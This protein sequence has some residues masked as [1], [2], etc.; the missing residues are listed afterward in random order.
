MVLL[1]ETRL[2]VEVP[3]AFVRRWVVVETPVR[4]SALLLVLLLRFVLENSLLPF[5][6]LYLTGV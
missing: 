1:P 4:L 3:R 2:V 6:L 5:S